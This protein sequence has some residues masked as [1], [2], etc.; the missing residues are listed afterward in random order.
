MRVALA[1]GD[2]TS[3]KEPALQDRVSVS[4]PA[5]ESIIDRHVQKLPAALKQGACNQLARVLCEIHAHV[6]ADIAV[7]TF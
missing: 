4:W 5:L 7:M 2:R 6:E 3:E 1:E